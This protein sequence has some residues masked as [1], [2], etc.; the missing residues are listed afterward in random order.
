MKTFKE[1][2]IAVVLAFGVCFSYAEQIR[3]TVVSVTDGD[4]CSIAVEN[5]KKE[6]VKIR[7]YGIDA[8][9]L[10]QDYGLEA[11]SYLS[12][13]IL[14]KNVI[15]EIINVDRYGRKVCT[16]LAD[17]ENVNLKMVKDGY[18][19]HYLEYAKNNKELKNAEQL[20]RLN[21]CG[22]WKSDNPIA[23]WNFRKNCTAKN[24]KAEDTDRYWINYSSNTTHNSACRWYGR[25]DGYFSRHG[26][27]KN[28][29]VCGG[30]Q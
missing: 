29:Q 21:K 26:S 27:G 6:T 24:K 9:E 23:P 19:W 11:K 22:L 17:N 16:I 1:F 15:A 3:G 28:C 14:T 30:E 10:K 8:P 2:F 7:L 18:A 20:A 5:A 25:T 13:L 12:S 4:T